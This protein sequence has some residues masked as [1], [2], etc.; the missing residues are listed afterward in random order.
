MYIHTK[1]EAGLK[2]ERM[3]AKEA[4]SLLPDSVDADATCAPPNTGISTRIY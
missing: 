1:V 3:T 4:A 2:P